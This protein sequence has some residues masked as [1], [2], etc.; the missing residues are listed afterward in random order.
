MTNNVICFYVLIGNVHISFNF[1][2][3]YIYIIGI[4]EKLDYI[5][6][7]LYKLFTV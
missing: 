4:F 3:M 2:E 6:I 7:E 5:L 1:G